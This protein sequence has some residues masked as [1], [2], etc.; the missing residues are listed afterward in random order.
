MSLGLEA[1]KH[2]ERWLRLA[3][4]H[5]IGC[6]LNV[7]RSIV[8]QHGVAAVRVASAAGK[9]AT[10]NIHLEA[11]AG[12]KGMMDIPQMNLHLVDLIWR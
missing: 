12:R 9:V 8:S 2:D 4:V 10:G 7:G 11:T 6:N 5:D 1:W 3:M